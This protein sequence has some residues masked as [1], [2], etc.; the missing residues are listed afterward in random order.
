MSNTTRIYKDIDLNFGAHPIT[1]DVTKKVGEDA[2]IQSV[3]NLLQLSK[4]EKLFRPDI[5]SN[6]KKHLFEPVD[7]IT[8]SAIETEVEFTINK[9]EPRVQVVSVIAIPDYDY[10]G[11]NVTITFFIVNQTDPVSIDLFLE[12]IR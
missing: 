4:Y 12:R 6:L 1:G 3:R 2:I 7:Q 8:A 9:N 10:Q 11:Y 5:Y